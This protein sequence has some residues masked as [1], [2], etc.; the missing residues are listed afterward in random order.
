MKKS[1]KHLVSNHTIAVILKNKIGGLDAVLPII[2]EVARRNVNAKIEFHAIHGPTYQAI[3]KNTVLWGAVNAIGVLPDHNKG[4]SFR[5]KL[6][7]FITLLRLIVLG[8]LG[9]AQFIHFKDNKQD[10]E[11]KWSVLLLTLEINHLKL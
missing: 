5:N 11:K 2:M 1:S 6:A 4:S 7:K 3:K 9:R 8:L 10:L